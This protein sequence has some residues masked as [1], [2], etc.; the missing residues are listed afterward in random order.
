MLKKTKK[1]LVEY[2]KNAHA[3]GNTYGNIAELLNNDGVVSDTG[4]GKWNKRVISTLMLSRG[5]RIRKSKNSKR[6]YNKRP[7]EKTE[8]V[9]STNKALSASKNRFDLLNSIDQ[10]PGLNGSVKAALLDLVFKEVCNGGK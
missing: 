9:V 5:I 10:C 7:K 2:I 6:K 8:N 3:A 4:N 1:D